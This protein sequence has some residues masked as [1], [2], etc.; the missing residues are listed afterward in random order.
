MSRLVKANK[1]VTLEAQDGVYTHDV[2]R[3]AQPAQT[4]ASFP[5]G[6]LTSHS[7][8]DEIIKEKYELMQAAGGPSTAL[9][10]VVAT[11]ADFEWLQKKRET[12]AEANLDQWIGSNFHTADVV[13]RKW[14]QETYPKYYEDRERLMIDRAK[15]ALRIKLLKLRGPKNQK[16]LIL[17]WGLQTGRIQLDRNW[18]VIGAYAEPGT[19]DQATEQQR[20]RNGLFSPWR[21]KSDAERISNANTKTGFNDNPFKPQTM[22]PADGQAPNP[23]ATGNAVTNGKGAQGRY[24]EFLNSVIKQAYGM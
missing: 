16:D 7:S 17:Q 11:D 1:A 15:L 8:R 18:D 9:G 24:P 3:G 10:Q 4:T 12:E 20:F 23:F 19:V 14:L 22:G 2:A 6:G 13:K 5:R 21:Y